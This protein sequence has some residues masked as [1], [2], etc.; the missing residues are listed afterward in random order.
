MKKVILLKKENGNRHVYPQHKTQQ[1]IQGTITWKYLSVKAIFFNRNMQ[2]G[3]PY[4][5]E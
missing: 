1:E 4:H 5:R 3:Q 2:A